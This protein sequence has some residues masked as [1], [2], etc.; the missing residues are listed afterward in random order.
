MMFDALIGLAAAAATSMS[1]IP[2]VQKAWPRIS[3]TDL[4]WRT[5]ALLTFGLVLWI[6]YGFVR[7]D[8]TVLCANVLGASLSGIVLMFKLRYMRSRSTSVSM[9][10]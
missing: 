2:Q 7:G 1:Y 8:M 10:E 9:A 4:S 3:T 5:L 6:I